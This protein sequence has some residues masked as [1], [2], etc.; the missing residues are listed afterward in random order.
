M[1]PHNKTYHSPVTIVT[2]NVTRLFCL[3]RKSTERDS[4]LL[5]AVFLR[6]DRRQLLLQERYALLILENCIYLLSVCVYIS[7]HI[8][9]PLTSPYLCPI[10][11]KSEGVDISYNPFLLRKTY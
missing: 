3:K 10:I 4:T 1:G 2:F 9:A 5:S 6:L 7:R 11:S 8:S